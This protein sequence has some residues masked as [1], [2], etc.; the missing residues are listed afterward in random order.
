MLSYFSEDLTQNASRGVVNRVSD[1]KLLVRGSAQPD[2]KA[3][4]EPQPWQV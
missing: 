1:V 2:G 4:S 3:A